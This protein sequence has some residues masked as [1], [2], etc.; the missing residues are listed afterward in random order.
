MPLNFR[1]DLRPGQLV[2]GLD[3]NNRLRQRLAVAE[4]R[5][6]LQLGFA[7]AKIQEGLGLTE[8]LDDP[9]V[10]AVKMLT[11]PALIFFLIASLTRTENR[12]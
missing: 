4:T 5:R 8:L 1:D 3:S 2:G 7:R 9:V 10:V 11:V 6:E 12:P